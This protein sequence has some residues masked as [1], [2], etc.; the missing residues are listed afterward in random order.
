[1]LLLAPLPFAVAAGALSAYPLADRLVLWLVPVVA[2]LLTGAVDREDGRRAVVVGTVLALTA[3]PAVLQALPLAV[4]TQEVEELRPVLEQVAAQRRRGDL[5]LVDIAAKGAFDFYG[6]RLGV[7][8]D[9]VVLF[10]TPEPGA[11]CADDLVA[12]RTGRFG[13]GR[14]WLVFSHELVEGDVLGTRDDL[15]GRIGRVTRLV[16]TVEDTGAAALLLSPAKGG[17]DIPAA[18]L[19]DDRC[20]VVNR[21]AR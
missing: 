6:P 3:G 17:Q 14:V 1:A 2:V 11:T 10:R 7:P 16:E 9:G 13:N 12:L 4:R 18:P 15:L 19:T 21:S 8:R 20:L 5:V